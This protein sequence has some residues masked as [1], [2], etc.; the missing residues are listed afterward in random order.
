[1][2]KPFTLL[3][4]G[5]SVLVSGCLVQTIHDYGFGV[6]GVVA[7]EDGAPVED[8]EV[9]LEVKGVV[10]EALTPLKTAI[11]QTD[12][13]GKF[14]FMYISHERSVEYTITIRKR[15]FEPKTIEGSSA[16][17]AATSLLIQLKRSGGNSASCRVSDQA[18]P[19]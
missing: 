2:R 17:Q 8:A 3:F 7:A 6:T 10:Y 15:G 14:F 4:F 5:V 1:M 16:A 18:C 11:H 19:Y 12:A 13:L 9:T